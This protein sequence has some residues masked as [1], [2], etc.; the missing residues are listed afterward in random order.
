MHTGFTVAP[1]QFVA[2]GFLIASMVVRTIECFIETK[3][4]KEDDKSK[5]KRFAS[6]VSVIYLTLLAMAV[7]VSY[8]SFQPKPMRVIFFAVEFT[9]VFVLFLS[10]PPFITESRTNLSHP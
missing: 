5:A 1:V 2:Y 7:P 10:V 6:V 3:D 8:I 9:A 4:Q